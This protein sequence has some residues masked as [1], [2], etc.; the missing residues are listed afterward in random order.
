VEIEVVD[1]HENNLKILGLQTSDVIQLVTGKKGN[2][3]IEYSAVECG[4][5]LAWKRY[6]PESEPPAFLSYVRDR[7]TWRKELPF[8]DEVYE[9]MAHKRYLVTKD[10][11]TGK[12][13]AVFAYFDYLSGWDAEKIKLLMPVDGTRL[14][15]LKQEKIEMTVARSRP[16][17][18]GVLEDG[19]LTVVLGRLVELNSD[20]SEDRL[21]S[22][23]GHL[24]LKKYPDIKFAA[25]K[26]AGGRWE[27]RSEPDK[28]FKC[29]QIAEAY[30]GGGHSHACGC[31][32]E[33]QWLVH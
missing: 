22:D 3:T 7:D 25:M 17:A 9:F 21:V 15:Q 23:I 20:G 24:I 11:K 26:T 29:V 10:L 5:T 33:I 31:Q 27:L 28:G 2:L 13:E 12:E 1:H 14:L 6:F 19:E 30:G 4:A 8:T 32:Q 16:C 18:Y